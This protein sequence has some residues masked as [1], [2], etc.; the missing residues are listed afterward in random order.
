LETREALIF[1]DEKKRINGLSYKVWK[2]RN[3]GKIKIKFRSRVK[4]EVSSIT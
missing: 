2:L 3:F 1:S 4:A